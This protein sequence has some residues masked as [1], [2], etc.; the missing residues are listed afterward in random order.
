MGWICYG[1]LGLSLG[2]DL[3]RSI[4]DVT[5]C[6]YPNGKYGLGD[7]ASTAA[8]HPLR[9]EPATILGF[10]DLLRRRLCTMVSGRLGRV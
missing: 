10:G 7:L 6:G 2:L 4:H 1:V 8:R 9:C 5:V 3:A